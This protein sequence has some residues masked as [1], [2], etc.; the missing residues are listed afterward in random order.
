MA[1]KSLN[2]VLA[3]PVAAALALSFVHVAPAGAQTST[4]RINEVVTKGEENDWVELFNPGEADVDISGWTAADDGNKTPITFTQGTTVPAGG[5]FVFNTDGETPDGNT[6]GLGKNDS[7]TLADAQGNV[8]DSFSWKAHPRILGDVNTSW[9]RFGDEW[10][11]S[12]RSTAGEANERLRVVVNE[13]VSTGEPDW[14]ELANPTEEEV[15]IGGWSAIDGGTKNTPI[16]FPA[17]TV[18]PAGG[19]FVF[20]TTQTTPDGSDGFGLGK[21]DEITIRDSSGEVVDA[22]SYDA[23]PALPGG[24][25]TSWGR[26]PDR[27]GEFAVTG[28]ATREAANIA[29]VSDQDDIVFDPKTAEPIESAIVVNEIESNGDPVADWVELYNTGEDAVDV[30]GWLVIDDKDD[31]APLVFPEGTVVEPKGFFRFYTEGEQALGGGKGFGLGSNDKVRIYTPNNEK[32]AEESWSEH[33]PGTLGRLPDGTGEFVNADPTPGEPNKEYVE[34]EPLES[35]AWP[36]DPMEVRNIDLGPEFAVEDMSGVDFD[37]EGRAWIANNSTGTLLAVDYDEDAQAYSLAGSWQLRYKDGTGNPDAEGVTVGHDGAIYVATERDNLNKNVSRPSI[38]RFEVPTTDSGDL[39]A[40]HE[41]NLSEH[42]GLIG[43]NAGLEAVSYIPGIGSN[44]YA[45]GVEATGE[46]LFVELHD[47]ETTEL[48]QRYDSPFPGVMALDWDNENSQLRVMCDQVCDGQSILLEHNGTEFVEASKVQA[49]PAAMEVNFENEGFAM[50][51]KVGS[52]VAGERETTL[53]FLWAD[54]GLA[55]GISLRG[56]QKVLSE[57]CEVVLTTVTTTVTATK[58]VT[59]T[60][61]EVAS[62]VTTTPTE[63]APTVTTTATVTTTVTAT[64]VA[65]TTTP[66]SET[67]PAGSSN[68]KCVAALVGWSVPLVALVPVALIAQG[69]LP[70]GDD[71]MAQINGAIA[72]ANAAIQRQ[73]GITPEMAEQLGLIA[74]AAGGLALGALAIATIVDACTDVQMSS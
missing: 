24:E 48:V 43:P 46:V 42:T 20:N 2:A 7:I 68:G 34:P 50:Y 35:V 30:S 6:F 11:V 13:L 15:N 70:V 72:Q 8:V 17:D 40:T 31:A 41:W 29:Y 47:D 39:S 38:L 58:T 14:V 69:G 27:Y 9:S 33:A 26:I 12:L 44:L 64:E 1:G 61:T 10:Q 25:N 21:N 57:P 56:A 32:V 45:T 74:G 55:N 60:P 22:F 16:V 19:Y 5:Y 23:H 66:T 36:Y 52:C 65:A 62:T 18:I 49:R 51:T 73:L 71:I 53:R 63:V 54:D 28:K 3:A 59:T 67:T 37:A 4:I